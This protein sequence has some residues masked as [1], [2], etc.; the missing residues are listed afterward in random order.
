MGAPVVPPSPGAAKAG[1]IKVQVGTPTSNLLVQVLEGDGTRLARAARAAGAPITDLKST[2]F[3][4]TVNGT[5]VTVNA[6][7]DIGT[8]QY[9]LTSDSVNDWTVTGIKDVVITVGTC[10]ETYD[11]VAAANAITDAKNTANYVKGSATD[12]T[13]TPTLTN[14]TVKDVQIKEGA[15]VTPTIGEDGVITVPAAELDK[16]S[17]G[18]VKFTLES[19][20]QNE[21]S[22]V[23]VEYTITVKDAPKLS[24]TTGETKTEGKTAV[25]ETATYPVTTAT[26]NSVSVTVAGAASFSKKVTVSLPD[27]DTSNAANAIREALK[28]DGDVSGKYDI[29]GSAANIVLTAKT[30]TEGQNV[31]LTVEAGDAAKLVLG[32]VT[33]NKS[34]VEA[35]A[36]VAELTVAAA[37]GSADVGN[38]TLKIGTK[39]VQ[40]IAVADKDSIDAIVQKIKAAVETSLNDDVTVKV[41]GAKLTFTE[42][43]TKEGTVVPSGNK[44]V[45][46][47]KA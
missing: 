3:N 12:V 8:Q 27:T 18:Q 11:K 13:F 6:T 47:T 26:N 2:D 46:F 41:E 33:A 5:P 28:G 22:T 24:D 45:T 16:Q 15:V 4:V 21:A 20:D 44:N 36:G 38:W 7:F 34:G 17:A 9:K 37:A 30:P 31:T 29:T 10:S 14:L 32:S 19:K 39:T 25:Q 1:D 40:N 35:V 42:K 23:K 43:S